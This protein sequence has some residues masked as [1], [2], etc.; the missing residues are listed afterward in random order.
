MSCG[1]DEGEFA[2]WFFLIENER[3]LERRAVLE[4]VLG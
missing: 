2:L 1:D 3:T 4:N